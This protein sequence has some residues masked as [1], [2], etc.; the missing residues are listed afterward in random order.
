MGTHQDLNELLS[1]G[2]R[3]RKYEKGSTNENDETNPDGKSRKKRSKG[4]TSKQET[5]EEKET[6]PKSPQISTKTFF[7]YKGKGKYEDIQK[8]RAWRLAKLKERA[9]PFDWHKLK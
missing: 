7:M 6:K 4:D 3:R 2:S 1:K 8:E 9:K 5:K